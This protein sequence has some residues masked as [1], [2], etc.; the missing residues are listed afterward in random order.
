MRARRRT[1]IAVAALATVLVGGG[2]TYAVADVADPAV[3]SS[4]SMGSMGSITAGQPFD[5]QFLD[6]M[7]VHHEGA[8]MSTRALIADSSRPELRGLPVTATLTSG[9]AITA[10]GGTSPT[11][12]IVCGSAR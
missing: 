5:A 6:Q 8:I 4:P 10:C 2:V 1:G 7:I 11:G 12:K 9:T 3:S